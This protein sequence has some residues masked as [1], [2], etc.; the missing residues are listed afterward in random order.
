[1]LPVLAQNQSNADI[2]ALLS[3]LPAYIFVV[4][5]LYPKWD[6]GAVLFKRKSWRG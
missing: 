5:I 3:G 4:N 2:F 1:M 6:S